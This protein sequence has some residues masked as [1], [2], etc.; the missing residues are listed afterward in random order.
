MDTDSKNKAEIT[1]DNQKQDS[2]PLPNSGNVFQSIWIRCA[3]LN[4]D[5]IDRWILERYSPF[6]L[7]GG[8]ICYFV[9]LFT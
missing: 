8:V 3:A 9:L 7:F 6:V 1:D 4:S 2:D 5:Q